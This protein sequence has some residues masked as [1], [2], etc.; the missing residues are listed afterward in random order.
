MQLVDAHVAAIL[1]LIPRLTL[2]KTLALNLN[3]S[4]AA[5]RLAA[6]HLVD[7]HLAADPAK[8]MAALLASLSA[9]LHL[10]LPHVNVL[11]KVTYRFP[12]RRLQGMLQ[13]RPACVCKPLRH[14][15][16][17]S[18]HQAG[19]SDV[20]AVIMRQPTM[21]LRRRVLAWVLLLSRT[22]VY[23]TLKTNRPEPG[24][25]FEQVDLIESYGQLAFNLDFYTEVQDLGR[26][27][28]SMDLDRFG[29]RFQ[30]L[31]SGLCE[32]C[33]ASKRK[34]SELQ[35]N[36]YLMRICCFSTRLLLTQH[37][38]V[39]CRCADQHTCSPPRRAQQGDEGQR[40]MQ[41]TERPWPHL[42]AC[43]VKHL[44]GLPAGSVRICVPFHDDSHDRAS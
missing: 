29:R 39:M 28:Y 32:A 21:S 36:V 22:A 16:C 12:C 30:K 1:T 41:Q 34:N 11:S 14:A 44:H 40:C 9:M 3:L 15:L 19:C 23:H 43:F 27:V 37:Y 26:L 24:C 5:V 18:Q 31:S 7:A 33:G 42:L 25:F 4:T 6:V 13:T 17:H 2:G 20:E 8:Y 38:G 35:Q 10:Q